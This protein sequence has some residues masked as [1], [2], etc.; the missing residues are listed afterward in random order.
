VGRVAPSVCCSTS[1]RSTLN[2]TRTIGVGFGSVSE[3]NNI[4][5]P[6]MRDVARASGVSLA[7]VSY[8]VNDGPRPVSERSR[9]RVQGAIRE[10]GYEARRRR[11]AHLTIG[12]VVPD[13]TNTFFSRVVAGVQ[14]ALASGGHHGLV[15]SSGDESDRELALVRLLLRS[16]VDGLLITPSAGIA[17]EVERLPGAGTPVVVMD[18]EGGTTALNRVTMNNY[19][20]A[21]KA[22]RLLADGG[23]RRIALLNGPEHVDTARDR[24]RGYADALRFAGLAP[25]PQYV[26]SVPFQMER[27]EQATRELL[28][29]DPPPTAIFSSSVVLTAGALTALRERSL[30]WPEDVAIVGFGDAV[31][32]PMVSP[33]LTVVE[34]PA[35]RLGETAAQLLLSTMREGG[36]RTGQRVVLESRI[37]LRDSHWGRA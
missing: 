23:H 17:E 6:T 14:A 31:W 2:L 9:R 25:A 8:V 1:V 18:R 37:V 10:L 16:R 4:E 34:Q 7:T 20:S 29:L 13:A 26:R 36:P 27:G 35:E 28:A 3:S 24:R 22:V 12:V 5:Q 21:F 15:A 11:S 30:R 19:D 32:A 33:A